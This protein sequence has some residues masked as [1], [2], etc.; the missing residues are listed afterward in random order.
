MEEFGLAIADASKAIEL[1]PKY[2][3]AYYRRAVSYLAVMKYA[4]ALKDFRAVCRQGEALGE[5]EMGDGTDADGEKC[6][7]IRM[8]DS[9][10][11]SARR[12]SAKYLS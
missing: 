10:C 3:K 8:P 1:D 6:R 9:R 12:S 11:R 4:D 7:M 2:I 5:C